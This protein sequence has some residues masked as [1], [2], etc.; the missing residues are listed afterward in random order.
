VPNLSTRFKKIKKEI[1]KKEIKFK[2]GLDWTLHNPYHEAIMRFVNCST[3][4]TLVSSTKFD[5]GIVE[6]MVIATS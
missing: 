6:F 5:N 3:L 1:K 4:L 2:G